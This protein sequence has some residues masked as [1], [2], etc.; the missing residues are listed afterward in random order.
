[1]VERHATLTQNPRAEPAPGSPNDGADPRQHWEVGPGWH[2]TVLHT[3]P[4]WFSGRMVAPMEP[5][6]LK[7][8]APSRETECS[9]VESIL[10]RFPGAAYGSAPGFDAPLTFDQAGNIYGTTQPGGYMG[11]AANNG[12][13]VVFELTP[14]DG[15]WVESVL[16]T[17]GESGVGV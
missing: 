17:F 15:A 2:F 1:M 5:R 6:R 16:H 9:W 11:G 13:G 12:C 7:P 14:A 3:L 8:P 10:Y 4:S